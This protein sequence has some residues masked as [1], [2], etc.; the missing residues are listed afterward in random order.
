[1][2]GCIPQTIPN[3]NGNWRSQ[4]VWGMYPPPPTFLYIFFIYTQ[5][6]QLTMN[7][8]NSIQSKLHGSVNPNSVQYIR[9]QDLKVQL[10]PSG[11]DFVDY[12]GQSNIYNEAHSLNPLR[13]NS[14]A[15]TILEKSPSTSP[16]SLASQNQY[17]IYLKYKVQ[18][19]NKPLIGH[20]FSDSRYDLSINNTIFYTGDTIQITV[21][22]ASDSTVDYAITGDLTTANLNNTSL[23]G[24]LSNIVS[25]LQYSIL[26]GNGNF[27]FSLTGVSPTQQL[28]ATIY[29]KYWVKVVTNWA[30]QT[31]FAFSGSGPSGIYY[32]QPNLSFNNGDYLLFDV[33]DS[34]MTDNSL[35][36]G[37][38]LDD[39]TTLD[40][41]YVSKTDNVITL[42]LT[43]Y[44]GTTVYYFENSS[45]NMGY[46][47][48]PVRNIAT[49]FSN[50]SQIS[51]GSATGNYNNRTWNQ[52]QYG[53]FTDGSYN[54]ITS[55]NAQ[56]DNAETLLVESS[57]RNLDHPLR[58]FESSYDYN[59]TNGAT[60]NANINTIV[61]GTNYYGAY[62][63][64]TMPYKLV[65]KDIYVRGKYVPHLPDWHYGREFMPKKVFI[66]GSNDNGTTL[67]F[68][69]EDEIP[70]SSDLT[71]ISSKVVSGI[72]EAYSTIRMV[73]NSIWSTTYSIQLIV[74]HL[75]FTGDIIDA[76]TTEHT[77]KVANG[78]FVIDGVSKYNITF[79]NGETY[80]FDQSD[81]S[82]TGFPIVFGT[83]PESSNL[84]TT[85]VTVVGTPGQA[86]AYTRIDYI[87]TTGALYYYSTGG[88]LM[89]YFNDY[90]VKTVQNWTGQDVFSIMSPNESAFVAQPDLSFNTGDTALFY[91]GDSSMTDNSYNLVFG[92]VV[93]GGTILDSP[94]VSKTDNVIT[95][96]LTNYSGT[97]VYY[98]EDSN[99]NMG[100]VDA[101]PPSVA[102]AAPEN[103]WAKMDS[104]DLTGSGNDPILTNHV[105]NA[106]YGN[107]S[108]TYT[109]TINTTDKKVGSGSIYLDHSN[110]FQREIIKFPTRALTTDEITL[111]D[112]F[113]MK[114]TGTNCFFWNYNQSPSFGAAGFSMR[115]ESDG[116]LHFYRYGSGSTTGIY[117]SINNW[118]H[119]CII[120]KRIADT[121]PNFTE[122]EIKI[123]HNNTLKKTINKDL[124]RTLG[125][126]INYHMLGSELPGL[127]DD[128]RHYNRALSESEINDIYNYVG[129]ITVH[130]KVVTVANG[131][132][133]IDDVSKDNIT[134]TNGETY[135]F[136]Q[137]DPSNAG[138]PIVFGTSPESS[139]LYTT[140]VTVVGTP[141]QAGAYTKLEEY[142]GTTGAL[143][144]YNNTIPGM[145]NDSNTISY[146]VTVAGAP[147]KF[148]LNSALQAVTFTADTK[149]YFYQ[150]DATNENYPIVFDVSPDDTAPYFTDGVTTVGTPGQAGSYTILDLSAGFTD[151]L[152]YFSSGAT[153]MGSF[154]VYTVK[155]VQNWAGDNVFSIQ[156][157]GEDISYNQPNLSFNAG[158][159]ALFDVGDS[160]IT[161]PG[162]SLV[163]GTE[164]DNSGT[165]LSSSYVS[166]TETLISLNLPSDY[167][168]GAVYYFENTNAN[169]GYVEAPDGYISTTPK[170]SNL[171]IYID[172]KDDNRNGT[173]LTNL[174]DSTNNATIVGDVSYNTD[175]IGGRGRYYL[176][177]GHDG[178]V[179]A[180]VILP[181][182]LTSNPSLTSFTFS[183]YYYTNT[184]VTNGHTRLFG[185]FGTSLVQWGHSTNNINIGANNTNL[186]WYTVSPTPPVSMPSH[187]N[188]HH[189]CFTYNGTTT[190]LYINGDNVAS[191]TNAVNFVEPLLLGAY[192]RGN[193]DP[194]LNVHTS[195]AGYYFDAVHVYDTVLSAS[196]VTELYNNPYVSKTVNLYPVTVSN[197]AF[198]IDTGSGAQ[199]K[200]PITFTDGETYI[201]DQ[202]D[203]SNA[204]YPIVFGVTKD[205]T[206]N[207]YTTDVTVVGT[208]GQPGAYTRIDYTGTTA[209]FYFSSGAINMGL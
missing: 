81:P 175:I 45:A 69:K 156:A 74:N 34:S 117:P 95:L 60:A 195:Y 200:P 146:N 168:G 133:V 172:A 94:F 39:N 65:L 57:D 101:P 155:V 197:E 176:P 59:P 207:L 123:Y 11:T 37:T 103:I 40:S 51:A 109:P 5:Q 25:S 136:D 174:I 150:Y 89:G 208:P 148:Y 85:N 19:T 54:V 114:P 161:G 166:Q 88:E 36:F 110:T 27:T 68:L 62:A 120:I 31:V 42:D 90:V 3:P 158:D 141:G 22:K 182:V 193:K 181:D 80:I 43:N 63:Q 21:L 192:Y 76:N 30:N 6:Q 190:T 199:S 151:S 8:L 165:I 191:S 183:I 32:E 152:F 198:F 33:G 98:F 46:V 145:G 142:A 52:T 29:R 130:S 50:T 138:F 73:V 194:T 2:G 26:S 47:E 106:N 196:E 140:N 126:T 178:L 102:P 202:S 116:E 177:F 122:Y 61:D 121:G 99:A 13:E 185:D 79:T 119:I 41:P 115:I 139:N 86:G 48:A 10:D 20:Y 92:T 56:S 112:A 147:P 173:S 7:L 171:K 149:Y 111:T 14:T 17:T 72:T 170:I 38:V 96:D 144:Y 180:S 107:I 66:F 71:H 169:M 35:V 153:N 189:L 58:G 163:F 160:S 55:T 100:Y 179:N 44:S 93:D 28:I 23:T 137:S 162:Y 135:I 1:M 143:Y 9:Q 83:S 129:G 134:F 49:N 78:V 84:Y 209:L 206:S 53:D 164:I 128:F 64:V 125:I 105:A 203:E 77:V 108:T 18:D 104:G 113:W 16:F 159:S 154:E 87:D 167:T 201:F 75:R 157:P 204:S 131:V 118:N 4:G 91:V 82:N 188:W 205:D 187:D 70:Y 186:E 12:T 24:T 67:T 15:L 124:N 184:D 127:Y 97:T 132:F